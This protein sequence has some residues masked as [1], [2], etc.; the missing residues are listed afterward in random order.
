[1]LQQ[2]QQVVHVAAAA[3]DWMPCTT[4][5]ADPGEK[6]VEPDAGRAGETCENW[7]QKAAKEAD[8]YTVSQT[9]VMQM[10]T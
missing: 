7:K 9:C 10:K 4:S 8:W 6:T 2:Q 1:M 5:S 3:G